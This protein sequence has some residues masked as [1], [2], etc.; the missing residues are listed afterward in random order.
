MPVP[1]S[2]KD[3]REISR[4]WIARWTADKA[5]DVKPSSPDAARE[6]VRKGKATVAVSIPKDFGADAGRAFFGGAKKP[7]IGVMYDPS[8][9]AE[10]AMVQG[11]LTGH[12]MQVVSK[13]MFA[14]KSGREIVKEDLARLEHSGLPAGEKKP[15]V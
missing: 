8:H 3:G 14:G 13:E 5:L 4:E 1:A 6:A 10:L 15:L 7:E 2:D 9:S 12:V 11:I